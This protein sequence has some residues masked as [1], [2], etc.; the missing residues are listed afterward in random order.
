MNRTVSISLDDDDDF[1]DSCDRLSSVVPLDLALVADDDDDDEFFD[2]NRMSFARGASI[3]RIYSIAPV[4]NADSAAVLPAYDMWIAEPGDVNERR[5][6]LL[7]GMGLVSNKNLV[8]IATSKVARTASIKPAE[9]AAQ[10]STAA[11]VEPSPPHDQEPKPKLQAVPLRA[12]VLVRSRSDGDIDV[13]SNK[14]KQRK[15]ETIGP[16]SKNKL[17][18][19]LS[20]K[21]CPSTGGACQLT[22]GA[23]RVLQEADHKNSSAPQ[24]AKNGGV[25]QC[26]VS[27]AAFFL[28]KNLDT[29]SDF[30]VNEF[31]EQGMWNKLNDLQTGKQL[32]MDEFEKSVGY[33]PVVKELMR[34]VSR[35]KHGGEGRKNSH[36]AKSFR[37]STKK[38]TALLKN[39]KGAASGFLVVEKME[40]LGKEAK[41]EKDQEKDPDKEQEKGPPPAAEEK[42]Q[43]HSSQWVEAHQHGKSVKEFTALHYTQEI[44]AHEG[45]IWTM[46]F[47]SDHRFLA[48]GGEDTN[49]HVWEVQQC[50]LMQPKPPEESTS[51]AA[52]EA[53]PA[54]ADHP[55]DEVDNDTNSNRLALADVATLPSELR[56]KGK[57]TAKGTIPDYVKLPEM[58]VGLSEKPK[59]SLKG[60]KDEVLDL[61]W[62]QSQVVGFLS[63]L[64][65]TNET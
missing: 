58:V 55:V 18:R 61:S 52:A 64:Q 62:S 34:R 2:S 4:K 57:K 27:D 43:R 3:K 22:G 28:I 29:G 51:E 8:R 31:N 9:P 50:E 40:K 1:F 39:L 12:I 56:K 10:V 6:R 65:K 13:F 48:T 42:V 37:S 14:T 32:T 41:E 16:V 20:A 36:F 60:H 46:R 24:A 30:I 59:Y 7:Q 38:G 49:V 23:I 47:S 15:L 17:T 53:P 35:N 21:L 26:I 19:T 44:Q 63:S 45:S 54:D 33:S 5:K 25:S 11:A